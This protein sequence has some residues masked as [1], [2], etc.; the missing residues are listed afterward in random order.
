VN[1]AA[2]SR[3]NRVVRQQNRII[4]RSQPVATRAALKEAIQIVRSHGG[5]CEK[6]RLIKILRRIQR[7][8]ANPSV[9]FLIPPSRRLSANDLIIFGTANR[10]DI[11]TLT[12][13]ITFVNT[14]QNRFGVRMDVY[15]V[16]TLRL[17]GF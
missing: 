8:P 2:G 14:F 6:T 3:F 16:K 11:P 9:S 17:R 12:T 10:L 5:K 7:I 1:F 15:T 13:D 4:G